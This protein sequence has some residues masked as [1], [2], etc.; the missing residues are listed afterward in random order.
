MNGLF[1]GFV[2]KSHIPKK[3]TPEIFFLSLKYMNGLSEYFLNF[4]WKN[5]L[6]LNKFNKKLIDFVKK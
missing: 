2:K 5:I 6:L 3:N 4:E 1:S